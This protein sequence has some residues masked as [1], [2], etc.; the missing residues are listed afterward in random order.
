MTTDTSPFAGIPVTV[1]RIPLV[2][3]RRWHLPPA[4]GVT[5]RGAFGQAFRAGVCREPDRPRCEGCARLDDCL[6][7][8]WY[9]PGLRGSGDVRPIALRVDDQGVVGPKRPFSVTLTVLG[10]LPDPRALVSA[11]AAAAEAGLGADRVRHHVGPIAVHGAEPALVLPDRTAPWPAPASLADL[12]CPPESACRCR[13]RFRTPFRWTKERPAEVEVSADTLF[14]VVLMRVRGVQRM[15]GL[16]ALP[17]FEP[18]GPSVRVAHQAVRWFDGGRRSG[19]QEFAWVWL[20]GVLGEV[21]LEGDLAP[22]A[23]LLATAEVL[24]VGRAT[25]AG[26]GVV[27][28]DW[29]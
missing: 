29:G 9:D 25:S 22:L 11:V 20:G 17:R 26:L 23:P 14:R 27:E 4:A 16:P 8:G 15:L 2:P 10:A 1:V 28:L 7:P 6:V 5:L 24:Q 21:E 19:R 3:E 12:L 18:P 13:V